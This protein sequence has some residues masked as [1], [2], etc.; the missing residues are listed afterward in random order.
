MHENSELSIIITFVVGFV[1][2]EGGHHLLR[3]FNPIVENGTVLP[4]GVVAR[5]AG[6]SHPLLRRLPITG[7]DQHV[8]HI[9]KKAFEVMGRDRNSNRRALDPPSFPS[10]C[11][12]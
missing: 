7:L 9:Q 12:S 10:P 11:T 2:F 1:S 4:Q 5:S 6:I 8:P 3:A